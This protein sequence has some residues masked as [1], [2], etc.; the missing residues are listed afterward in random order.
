MIPNQILSTIPI[1]R[2]YLE[3]V[4]DYNLP[5]IDYEM[6]GVAL[7][8]VSQGLQVKLWTLYM[9]GDDVTISAPDVAPTVVFTAQNIT[10]LSL[11]FDQSMQPVI[12]FV[13]AEEARL[14]WYDTTVPGYTTTIFPDA[15]SPRVALD[16]KRPQF[17]PL[18]DVI[19][20]YVKDNNLY[21]R[22]QRDRYLIEYLLKTNVNASLVTIGM[23]TNLRFKFK[24]K[25]LTPI[26]GL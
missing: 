17:V 10:E 1:P 20:A 16:D 18:S 2:P 11:A 21:F 4:N 6:G 13:Q 26:G 15:T 7:N 12:A 22:A 19:L 24:M 3:K 8:D 5:L 9:V 25:T 23:T 14:Y